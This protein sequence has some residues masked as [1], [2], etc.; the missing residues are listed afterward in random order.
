MKIINSYIC[1]SS[2]NVFAIITEPPTVHLV[3]NND[4]NSVQ[5]GDLTTIECTLELIEVISDLTIWIT[6]DNTN[7]SQQ[8]ISTLHPDNKTYI[9]HT[10][11]TISFNKSDNQKVVACGAKWMN[12]YF[13]SE[14][15]M[16]N[17]MCKYTET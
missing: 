15:K 14:L 3:L 13:T 10:R 6:V 2:I 8:L 9:V 5:A 12:K 7:H 4:N 1:V 16:V 17:V 11:S